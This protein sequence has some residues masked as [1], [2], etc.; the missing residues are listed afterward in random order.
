MP[1]LKVLEANGDAGGVA[2]AGGNPEKE[3]LGTGRGSVSRD[4][5]AGRA[6][7]DPPSS[8][9]VRGLRL[10]TESESEAASAGDAGESGGTGGAGAGVGGEARVEA[11]GPRRPR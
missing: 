2:V 6:I 10:R 5:T 9:V 11:G 8:D 3:G 4:G 7:S 1:L